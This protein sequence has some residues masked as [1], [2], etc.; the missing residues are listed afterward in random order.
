MKRQLTTREILDY[1]IMS[2]WW[3]SWISWGW[4]QSLAARYFAWKVRT[5]GRRY[6]EAMGR[7]DRLTELRRQLQVG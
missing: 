5:K 3:S 6:R 2:S 7:A 4:A 1:E